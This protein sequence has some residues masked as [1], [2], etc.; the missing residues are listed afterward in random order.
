MKLTRSPIIAR[1]LGCAVLPAALAAGPVSGVTAP[2]THGPLL[3]HTL[4]SASGNW[5]GYA[6][7]K[8]PFTT[9]SASWKQP[10]VKCTN[11]TTYS[12]F[13]VGIDGDGSNT[14]EQT[15]TEA[16]CV[17]GKPVYSAWHEFYPAAPKNFNVTV[18]PGDALHGSVTEATGGV[19]TL[20]LTDTTQHWIARA[21]ATVKSAKRHSAE[22]IAEAPSSL[23]GVLPLADFGKVSF[24]SAKANGSLIGNLSPDKITMETS[25]GVVKAQPSALT[26]HENFSVTWHHV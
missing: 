9:V 7:T 21:R 5:S 4:N 22:I 3:I 16:D 15:G 23:S 2:I 26:S 24:T 13:W 1:L 17:S 25:G 10:A 11:Q 14:V 18:R 8:G 6:S 19:Y 20:T 12:S